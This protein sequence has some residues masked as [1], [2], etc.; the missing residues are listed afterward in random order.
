MMS[1]NP[2]WIPTSKEEKQRIA[3]KCIRD[4]KANRGQAEIRYWNSY[5]IL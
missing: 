3:S 4:L 5:L 1:W 2:K